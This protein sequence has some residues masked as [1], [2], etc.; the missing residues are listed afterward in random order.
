MPISTLELHKPSNVYRQQPDTATVLDAL[1]DWHGTSESYEWWWLVIDHGI[2]RSDSR[3]TAIRFEDVRALLSQRET[4]VAMTTLLG[5]LPPYRDNPV[6]WQQ[7]FPGVIT[8]PVIEQASMG[9]ARALQ[10]VRN[11]PGGLVVVVND[12]TLAGILSTSER[13]FAF[14]DNLLVDML[15]SFEQEHGTLPADLPND[16]SI[17]PPAP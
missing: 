10:L 17:N 9:T 3:F 7:P 12:G 16:P 6:N 13:T 4:Q 11:T 8:P 14:T 5:D 2:T 15:E 1:R